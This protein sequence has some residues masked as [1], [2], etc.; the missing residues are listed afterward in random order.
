MVN[1]KRTRAR[2]KPCFTIEIGGKVTFAIPRIVDILLFVYILTI[3][4]TSGK[5]L[6]HP[7]LRQYPSHHLTIN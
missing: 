5:L 1:R 2:L 3:T 7:V 6:R 4:L